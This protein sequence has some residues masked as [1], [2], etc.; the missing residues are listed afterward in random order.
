LGARRSGDFI[1]TDDDF[2]MAYLSKHTS[3]GAVRA[4]LTAMLEQIAADGWKMKL[5]SRRRMFKVL[6]KGVWLDCFSG[7]IE[8]GRV[9]MPQTTSF[10]GDESVFLP[11]QDIPFKGTVITIPNKPDVFLEAV[12]GPDWIVPDVGY[13]APTR[14]AEVMEHLATVYLSKAQVSAYKAKGVILSSAPSTQTT[15]DT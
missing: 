14:P 10:V 7:W 12:Y 3:S 13:V 15:A 1:A 6:V 9:W 4:E 5:N 2:D 8:D 11:L